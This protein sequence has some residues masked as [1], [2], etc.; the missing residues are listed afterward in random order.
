MFS[1]Q[2]SRDPAQP[3][4]AGDP[5]GVTAQ[6]HQAR[7]IGRMTRRRIRVGCDFTYVAEIDTPVIFQ[8]QPRA[9]ACLVIEQEQWRQLPSMA[10]R[11]Y[12]DLYGNPCTR[13][14]LP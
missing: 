3:Q 13:A 4:T 8:V 11:G 2:S 12:T 14:V 5:P 7:T 10:I 9:A 1:S 6:K